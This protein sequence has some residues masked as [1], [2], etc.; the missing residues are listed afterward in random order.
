[1]LKERT[2]AYDL[3]VAS[4]PLQKAQAEARI[5]VQQEIIR[6]LEDTIAEHT[7][8]APFDGFVTREHTEV[9]QWIAKGGSIVEIIELKEVEIEIPVLETFIS[10]L[11][12][13]TQSQPGTETPK[14]A[15][16]ALPEESFTGEIVSI[17]PKGD[18]QSHTFPVRIRLPNRLGEDGQFLLKPGMFA[19]VTLP[20][21]TISKNAI[22]IPKDALVLDEREPP[23]VWVVEPPAESATGGGRDVRAVTVEVAYEVSEGDLVEVV[24]PAGP[25]G[26]LPLKPQELV[27]TEGNERIAP[28]MKVTVTGETE[29][30]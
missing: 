7:I 21:K 12:Q 10:N 26:A 4:A 23:K 28:G 16:D 14:I 25:D 18:T 13:R 15:I 17:V 24:G 9:G 20:A 22:L 8:A 1:V 30:R 6:G 3:A 2:S 11:R 5:E 19:R 27:I 29:S